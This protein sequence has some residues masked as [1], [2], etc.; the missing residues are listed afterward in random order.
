MI[1]VGVTSFG[2]VVKYLL[3]FGLQSRCNYNRVCLIMIERF[4]TNVASGVGWYGAR[5][6]FGETLDMMSIPGNDYK[7]RNTFRRSFVDN[8]SLEHSPIQRY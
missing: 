1:R 3:Y 2:V 6:Q 4:R 5:G 7:Y 8:M